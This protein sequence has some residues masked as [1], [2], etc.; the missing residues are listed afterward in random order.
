MVKENPFSA[1]D[2]EGELSLSIQFSFVLCSFILWPFPVEL[3][4]SWFSPR[5]AGVGQAKM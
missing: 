4:L 2:T 5:Q 3:T 1:I